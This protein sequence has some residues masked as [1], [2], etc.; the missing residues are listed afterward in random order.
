MSDR[1]VGFQQDEFKSSD[2]KKPSS[3]GIDTSHEPTLLSRETEIIDIS[4]DKGCEQM[5]PE[6][7]YADINSGNKLEQDK[8]DEDIKKFGKGVNQEYL[9][10]ET[11]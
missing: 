11:K 5:T 10:P 4:K 3:E 8:F 1:D 7:V 6:E 9:Q 2:K